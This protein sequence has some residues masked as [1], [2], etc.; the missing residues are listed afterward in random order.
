M[1]ERLAKITGLI[2]DAFSLKPITPK[3]T[4]YPHT[5]IVR[6]LQRYGDTDIGFLAHKLGTVPG[7]RRFQDHLSNLEQDGVLWHTDNT[8]G[9]V[10]QT[11]SPRILLSRL[12]S[13]R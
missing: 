9:L 6:A 4:L 8:V 2:R 13:R 5:T 1:G 3:L 11:A 10:S 7:S 12:L